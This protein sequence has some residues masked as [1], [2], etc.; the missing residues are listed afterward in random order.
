[1]M[2]NIKKYSIILCVS[3][4][5]ATHVFA[6]GTEIIPSNGANPQG[7]IFL[8][9]K[10]VIRCGLGGDGSIEMTED[11]MARIAYDYRRQPLQYAEIINEAM[12]QLV[13]DDIDFAVKN[14]IETGW[15]DDKAKNMAGYEV[16]PKLENDGTTPQASLPQSDASKCQET[17]NSSRCQ[18]EANGAVV[19]DNAQQ[20]LK[21][22]RS[23]ASSVRSEAIK[24][25]DK[26]I[27]MVD[28]NEKDTSLILPAT[29]P[30]KLEDDN[31][32]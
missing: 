15:Q 11:C 30:G 10:F 5:F 21:L 14:M 19:N 9:E 29:V 20:L 17:Q 12:S 28:V 25:F 1:M 2:K 7:G 16:S 13:N 26:I 24:N 32:E 23:R 22:L 3:C 4:F 31:N 6:E 18:I 27:P 8:P